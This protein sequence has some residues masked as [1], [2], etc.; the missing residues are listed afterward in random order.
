MVA[1]VE[2]YGPGTLV[3]VDKIRASLADNGFG[4]ISGMDGNES[5]VSTST[6]YE[7]NSINN[8]RDGNGVSMIDEEVVINFNAYKY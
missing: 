8:G 6:G 3:D 2:Q 5:T 4:I 7:T 1:R